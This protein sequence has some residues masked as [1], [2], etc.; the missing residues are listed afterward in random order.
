[1]KN[2]VM[3][4]GKNK[5]GEIIIKNA[6]KRKEGYLY[7]IDKDGNICE[8]E[9]KKRGRPKKIPKIEIK[10]KIDDEIEEDIWE[11]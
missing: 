3:K 4:G 6:I 2:F 1:M 11:N 5:M 10:D 8:A 9:M 7:Y